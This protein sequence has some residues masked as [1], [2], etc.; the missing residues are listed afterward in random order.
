[1]R[2]QWS[3]RALDDLEDIRSYIEV[4]D[5]PAARRVVLGLL[6]AIE[7]LESRPAL[8]RPGRVLGTRELVHAPWL[9][10]YRV[11]AG[12]VQVLRVLHG[13]RRWPRRLP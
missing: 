7:A 8:G 5:L 3:A 13:A 11:E 4:D 1:M 12:V 2:I 9:V 10:A 6:K